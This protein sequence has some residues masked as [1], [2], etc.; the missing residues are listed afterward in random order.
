MK[1]DILIIEKNWEIIVLIHDYK[2]KGLD[3]I[4]DK[5]NDIYN[6]VAAN[7]NC[8]CNKNHIAFLNNIKDHLNSFLTSEEIDLLKKQEEVKVIQ[9]LKEN[10]EILEF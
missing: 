9:V 4:M 3:G 5:Y 2:L 6:K 10:K 8:S 1:D 7:P